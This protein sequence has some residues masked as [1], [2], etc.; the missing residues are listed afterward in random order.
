MAESKNNF[1]KSKMNKDMDNRLVP[2]GEYRDALNL[3]T[4]RSEGSNVGTVENILGNSLAYLNKIYGGDDQVITIGVL[5][6]ERNNR[7][8]WFVTNF[9]DTPSIPK[10]PYQGS[11]CA[12]LMHNEGEQTQPTI[13]VEGHF[14]NFS[15]NHLITGVN[16]VENLLFWTDG[17]NQPRRINVEAILSNERSYTREEQLSISRYAPYLAP[18]VTNLYKRD[19]SVLN[20]VN[21]Y[22]LDKFVRL[23]YR[24][25]FKDNEYSIIAPFTQI[26]FVPRDNGKLDAAA[27]TKIIHTALVSSMIN[28]ISSVTINIPMPSLD[29]PKYYHI[30]GIEI[31]LKSS[32]STAIKVVDYVDFT[33]PEFATTYT[34]SVSFGIPT[35]TFVYTY[36]GNKPYK[37]L[38]EDQYTRVYDNV[39]VKA[40]AQEIVGSRVV[41]GN[42]VQN[43][44][45]PQ[46]NYSVSVKQKPDDIAGTTLIDSAGVA[47]G[48]KYPQHSLKQK[49]AYSVGVV[50]SDV[51]G[52]QSSVILPVNSKDAFVYATY[53]NYSTAI[54]PIYTSDTNLW[55]GSGLSINFNALV[56]SSSVISSPY[57]KKVKIINCITAVVSGSVLTLTSATSLLTI[58]I[59][60]GLIVGDYLRGKYTENTEI[61]SLSQS[62]TGPYTT[63]VTCKL[64]INDTLYTTALAS[65]L[66]KYVIDINGWHSYKIVVK[67]AEQ[68][69]YNVYNMQGVSVQPTLDGGRKSYLTL[70]G[71]NINKVPRTSMDVNR[72]SGITVS[73]QKIYS[74]VTISAG[75]GNPSIQQQVT[76][77]E[78]I[79]VLSVGTANEYA[80]Y[81]SGTSVYLSVYEST[82]NHLQAEIYDLNREFGIALTDALITPKL[83]IYETKPTISNLDIYW[84]TSTSGLVEDLNYDLSLQQEPGTGEYADQFETPP[85]DFK[86]STLD[87]ASDSNSFSESLANASL[88]PDLKIKYQL[89]NFAL[90]NIEIDKIYDGAGVELTT[91]LSYFTI[92]YTSGY[93]RI[94]LSK[95]YRYSGSNIDSQVFKFLIKVTTTNPAPGKGGDIRT[96][97]FGKGF[98]TEAGLTLNLIN[99]NPSFIDT[100]TNNSF[101]YKGNASSENLQVLGTTTNSAVNGSALVGSTK[102]DLVYSIT[103]IERFL[104]NG[105]AY[106]TNYT[107]SSPYPNWAGS[108]AT[109]TILNQ[110]SLDWF[111]SVSTTGTTEKVFNVSKLGTSGR[112]L[113]LIPNARYKINIQAVDCNGLSGAM[114]GTK[115]IIYDHNNVSIPILNG[116]DAYTYPAIP[117]AVPW[118]IRNADISCFTDG[119]PITEVQNLTEFYNLKKAAWCYY[120]NLASNG[121][122]YGKLYNWY[123]V[124]G[125][126]TPESSTPTPTEIAARKKFAP[127]GYHIPSSAEFYFLQTYISQLNGSYLTDTLKEKGTAHWASPNSSAYNATG[128]TALPAGINYREAFTSLTTLTY[129]WTSNT[130][131]AN[132]AGAY[133]WYI[134]T[135]TDG[136]ARENR[137]KQSGCS[138]RFIKD[139]QPFVI[140]GTLF[141]ISS[142]NYLIN[143][144]SNQVVPSGIPLTG[145][146]IMWSTI[147]NPLYADKVGVTWLSSLPADSYGLYNFSILGGPIQPEHRNKTLYF[148]IIAETASG[149]GYGHVESRVCPA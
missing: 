17:F 39:P 20:G 134:D 68:D 118:A 74:K 132:G 22:L 13:L 135:R 41:Y 32:D 117:L 73:K 126:T 24:Y 96:H 119:T 54:R 12:I 40:Y 114:T 89:G 130:V 53:L 76:N 90:T 123:A 112:L 109:A 105:Y 107:G 87:G 140:T 86:F 81:S 77:K 91:P 42:Y 94:R 66:F 69:Y 37:T 62:G 63:T 26:L 44:K 101:L 67:Q 125:I 19:D 85:S 35:S 106:K 133:A 97:Y 50:L 23:S 25:K 147:E 129:F 59:N 92:S 111:D 1:L 52:R 142:T 115:S 141:S 60:D 36:G 122:E 30:N 120:G 149:Y 121:V 65:S 137:L 46:I 108:T 16:L 110:S 48:G 3:N 9:T 144:I 104:D 139:N 99:A 51:F 100:S 113:N 29:M 49:R 72:D 28:D 138:V 103:S 14:L 61:L 18:K 43:K 34:T 70:H 4:S 15:K 148:R 5:S 83:T 127:T 8:F 84:E 75:S 136:F 102:D 80:L 7:I 47:T 131:T 2:E 64:P 10:A 38:P 116:L 6:D 95:A 11:K 82:K 31:L 128:F 57:S 146:G 98:D 58:G 79:N 45:L 27:N 93:Y 88:I 143:C 56:G 124:M 78:A 145:L 21:D 33:R 55:N 71:D